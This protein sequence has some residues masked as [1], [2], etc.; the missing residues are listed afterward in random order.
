[1]KLYNVPNN[2]KIKVIK[3]IHTPPLSLPIGKDEILFFSHTDG[4]YSLCINADGEHVY[5]SACAD[6]KII[7]K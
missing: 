4:F 1:M 7:T 2:T 3:N 5:L 6:V